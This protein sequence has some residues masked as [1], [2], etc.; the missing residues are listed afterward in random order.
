MPVKALYDYEFPSADRAE[1]FGDDQLVY[2]HWDGNP[3]FCS[4]ACFRPSSGI[5]ICSAPPRSPPE[6]NPV[7][8]S[9]RALP[10]DLIFM[11][12]RIRP[13]YKEAPALLQVL[14]PLLVCGCDSRSV[15]Q[16]QA[17]ARGVGA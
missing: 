17:R 8:L 5:L 15:C 11:D 7:A 6:R 9:V 16:P 4:A 2:V 3:L 13:S 1:A 12:M 14:S 10:L